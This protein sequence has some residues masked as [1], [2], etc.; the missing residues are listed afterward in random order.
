MA[1]NGK[2]TKIIRNGTGYE[3]KPE[4]NMPSD[5]FT[6]VFG[7][8]PIDLA[9]RGLKHIAGKNK[10]YKPHKDNAN[11]SVD[12]QYINK[13]LIKVL[14]SSNFYGLNPN[15][16][17]SHTAIHGFTFNHQ[18]QK[19]RRST[20]LNST[21]KAWT[22]LNQLQSNQTGTLYAFDLETFGG[23]SQ[24]KRWNPAGIT[25]FAMRQ[26]D[27]AT[28]KSK[29]TNI[30]FTNKATLDAIEE[31]LNVYK[32]LMRDGIS[33]KEMKEK[34]NDVYVTA[35]RMSLYDPARGAAFE[36]VNGV[37]QA[38]AL[39]DTKEAEAGNVASVMNA[40][41]N[42]RKMQ[43]DVNEHTGLTADVEALIR[44]TNQMN[45]GMQT[46]EAVVM[47]HNIVNF[48]RPILSKAINDIY[49]QQVDIYRDK[50]LSDERRQQ[51]FNALQ[52]FHIDPNGHVGFNFDNMPVL[53]T[54]GGYRAVRDELGM[55][56]PSLQ[57]EY[58][59]ERYMPHLLNQGVSHLGINDVRNNISIVLDK[60][61]EL[62]GQSPFEYIMNEA[63]NG[64]LSKL[65]SNRPTV[66]L[67]NKQLFKATGNML[68]P[69]F[70]GK[71]FLNYI[72][73]N[74]GEIYTAGGYHIKDGNIT[75]TDYA[76]NTGF[77]K[78]GFYKV[79][80]QERI[81]VRNLPKEMQEHLLSNYP[82]YNSKYIYHASF[83]NETGVGSVQGHTVNVFATSQEE[84]E[85]I[86][87]S[88]LAHVANATDDGGW[89]IVQG[90]KDELVTAA[91]RFKNNRVYARKEKGSDTNIVKK[92]IRLSDQRS[93]NDAV[94]RAVYNHEKS[95]LRIQGMLNFDEEIRK[96][97]LG[98]KF[99]K[100]L[101]DN[102][103]LS[104]VLVNDGTVNGTQYFSKR[105]M[106]KINATL[107]KHIGYES[108]GQ[109]F[110]DERTKIN[111]AEEYGNIVGR[112]QYYTNLLETTKEAM[113]IKEIDSKNAT[114]ATKFFK[115]LDKKAKTK[116]I[117]D[118][119]N[120]NPTGDVI[121]KAKEAKNVY[122]NTKAYFKS[123]YDFKLGDRFDFVGEKA[124]LIQ[125]VWSGER[126]DDIVS[127]N[128][129]E[130][131]AGSKFLN[132]LYKAR[133][134]HKANQKNISQKE[135]DANTQQAFYSFLMDLNENR[136]ANKLLFKDKEFNSYMGKILDAKLISNSAPEGFDANEGVMYLLNAVNKAKKK[137]MGAGII[138]TFGD[139]NIFNMNPQMTK[140]LNNL[141]A[142]VIK[143][144]GK[145]IGKIEYYDDKSKQRYVKELVNIFGINQDLFDER[146]AGLNKYEK[147]RARII[148]DDIH[149]KLSVYFDDLL[150]ATGQHGVGLTIDESNQR[151]V[152][153][154][155]NRAQELYAMPKFQIDEHG[156]IHV[157]SGGTDVG[158]SLRLAVKNGK[159]YL[160]TN[161]D[162]SF[163][164][165]D[166]FQKIL[167]SRKNETGSIDLTDLNRVLKLH[168]QK[169]KEFTGYTG[170]KN[171]LSTLNS[172][173][174]LSA[175]SELYYEMFRKNG[176]LNHLVDKI[177]FNNKDLAAL[178]RKNAEKFKD[179]NIPPDLFMAGINDFVNIMKVTLD[180]EDDT[181]KDT[182]AMLEQVGMS[183]KETKLVNGLVQLGGRVVGNYSNYFDNVGRPPMTGAG[184]VKQIRIEDIKKLAKHGVIAGSIF[185]SEETLRGIYR[186]SAGIEMV[187]DFRARQAYMSAPII[188]TVLEKNRS[189]VLSANINNAT[190]EQMTEKQKQVVYDK[191]IENMA[192]GT[193]EQARV[194][195]GR[196]LN[197]IID[198]PI[199]TSYLSVNK[200]I[201]GA[202]G[203]GT[204]QDKFARLVDLAGDITYDENTKE[205]VYKRR[206]GSIV[207]KGESIANYVG[208]G[209][210]QN[211]YGSKYDLGLLSYSIRNKEN[212]ELSDEEVSKIINLYRER[213]DAVDSKED[214]LH[215]LT[216]VMGAYG[217]KTSYKIENINQASIYKV[218]DQGSEK[219]MSLAMNA[220]LGEYNKE[221]SEYFKMFGQMAEEFGLDKDKYNLRGKVVGREKAILAM[222][223]D[224]MSAVNASGKFKNAKNMNDIVQMIYGR[225][226]HKKTNQTIG[227]ILD[228]I[229]D[230]RDV[231][232]EMAFGE[233][234]AFKNLF[235]IVNDAIPKHE[236]LGLN[237]FANFNEA[238]YKYEIAKYGSHSEENYNKA[239]TF[240][241]EQ[242]NTNN[243]INFLRQ[244]SKGSTLNSVG[245]TFS[246][247][248]SSTAIVNR[249]EGEFD[250][251][252]DG[253][254]TN[255]MKF[256]N[257]LIIK[258]DANTPEE[259]KLVHE[260]VY[261]YK[262]DKTTGKPKLEKQETLVGSFKFI[263]EDGKKIAISATNFG[264]HSIVN[265]GETISGVTQEYINAKMALNE[266]RLKENLT[267]ED[268]ARIKELSEFVGSQK[269]SVKFM[270]IDDQGMT[271]MRRN[272]FNDALAE[273]LGASLR[274]TDGREAHFN[275]EKAKMLSAKTGDFIRYDN[276]KKSFALD[277]EI[278]NRGENQVWIE[279][280]M[281]KQF[282]NDYYGEEL[283]EEML[284][285]P[286]Y[287]HL[288]EVREYLTGTLKADKVGVY[289]AENYYNADG[290]ITAHRFNR[291]RMTESDRNALI[292]KSNF[293]LM[294]I[295]DYVSAEGSSNSEVIG[296]IANK[297]ILLDLGD[298]FD[299][300]K[301]YIAIPEGGMAVGDEEALAKWQ[302]KINHLKKLQNKLDALEGAGKLKDNAFYK[303]LS[304]EDKKAYIETLGDVPQN[305]VDE[306]NMILDQMVEARQGIIDTINEGPR[307]DSV[308]SKISKLEIT[309]SQERLKILS[310][311]STSANNEALRA[312][313]IKQEIDLASESF[314]KTAKIMQNDGTGISLHELQEKGVHYDVER[315]G[316]DYFERA[317]Y[318]D[319]EMLDKM[320]FTTEEEMEQYLKE[321]GTMRN[322][323]RYPEILDTSKF[324]TRIFYDESMNG[325]NGISVMAHSMLKYNGDSD[326]DSESGFNVTID[327]V[328]FAIF[329]RQKQIATEQLKAEGNTDTG[330]MFQKTLME[331]V[332]KNGVVTEDA[333][334]GFRDM[335]LMQDVMAHTE[336]VAWAEKA[337]GDI[338]DD[339]TKNVKVGTIGGLNYQIKD[340]VSDT[341]KNARFESMHLELKS[342]ELKENISG[343]KDAIS[344]VLQQSPD[345]FKD[346]TLEIAQ[347]IAGGESTISDVR[348]ANK[349]RILDHAMA[350][351]EQSHKNGIITDDQFE[352]MQSDL[353]KRVRT[354]Q[355]F[356]EQAS[357]S[358]KSAIGSINNALN[359]L[360]T[361]TNIM[362]RDEGSEFYDLNAANI[363]QELTYQLEQQVISGKKVAFELGD[364]RLLEV[365]DILK[366]A[367]LGKGAEAKEDLANWMDTYFDKGTTERIWSRM[368]PT[369]RE[370]LIKNKTLENA[371]AE[372]MKNNTDLTE[373][374][375]RIKAMNQYLANIMLDASTVIANSE[376][377]KNTVHHMGSINKKTSTFDNMDN[378]TGAGI[379]GSMVNNAVN[380]L[381]RKSVDEI[382][383]MA[384]NKGVELDPI[385]Q[386]SVKQT[387]KAITEAMADTLL[388]DAKL[389]FS[390]GAVLGMAAIGVGAGLMIAGYAGGGHSRPTPP[391]D[392]TQ[393]A[394]LPPD[395]DEGGEPGMQQ[396]GYVI[397]I[398]ADT[399]KGERHLKKTLKQLKSVSN[400]GNVNINMNYKRTNG[401]G[402][403]NK[404]IENI[405][406]NFI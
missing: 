325:K 227:G 285:D 258:L 191:L 228:L 207:K 236:N 388:K 383:K 187:S 27:F 188:Q 365:E 200:D 307:K 226:G 189:N 355:M 316:R 384:H 175:V 184:N 314:M 40:F 309:E 157:Q 81:E 206:A 7:N 149:D 298:E 171:D 37:W 125:D 39:V 217:L 129:N 110:L 89:Q 118:A 181:Y 82:E 393:P 34:H 121:S 274:L 376:G 205:Y 29:D 47:G 235:G 371:A 113:G 185:E 25:E 127:I 100:M 405:I 287:A 91:Y 63:K 156:V 348:G 247:G 55:E 212:K 172:V 242:M 241:T 377:G 267:K 36:Q 360:K 346:G 271:I 215:T 238:V 197:E 404:D 288:K 389:G 374:Q 223:E 144:L 225:N 263:E 249:E 44:A 69:E 198:M 239:L 108:K 289:E 136:K 204:N 295:K 173:F 67:N 6:A 41:K 220:T 24:D 146:T 366:K 104:E 234:G 150:S 351:I 385:S 336:N 335:S 302:G 210:V 380:F 396:H 359:A 281:K 260:D 78:G 266:L 103:S 284:K 291:G 331:R 31:Q 328:N 22:K 166:T 153:T 109:M 344:F 324:N 209:G 208:Y 243:D 343:V 96:G 392:D 294:S 26:H 58:L 364:T 219:G 117:M 297:R 13:D 221:V 178:Y 76:G 114:G 95:A 280:M 168:N 2:N 119:A 313:G 406:N 97:K 177:D 70:G 141:D 293:E 17:L 107:K 395:F 203:R 326:G 246:M 85:A 183:L 176:S 48:D 322:V 401:G 353:I 161:F 379:G 304:E 53:D 334:I 56:L 60:L 179:G 339:I 120:G 300:S 399:N 311:T 88:N 264:S 134:G 12:G 381:N 303:S 262:I 38:T 306:R 123:T 160:T 370:E 255:F 301:R 403:S 90:Q 248:Q 268:K 233:H 147:E 74:T 382:E 273:D 315:V 126:D 199:D 261:V 216:E 145:D 124:Q 105:D 283:T 400:G 270:K 86:L 152:A 368:R 333:Y 92:A 164:S 73:Y 327:G 195:D 363:T 98:T 292:Q 133:M 375:A 317:G 391:K 256:T 131:N 80:V 224:L 3:L 201:I 259:D 16:P 99:D 320:G 340:S 373:D 68:T 278:R 180:E 140:N 64:G 174:D 276:N 182:V 202:I 42:F 138:R 28:G 54:L 130:P 286:K 162:E 159:T 296:S 251:I 272:R 128:L 5:K 213:F 357:K 275:E 79:G 362:M 23:T 397:N 163:G 190:I 218:L 45:I 330:A 350:A 32:Q 245:K 135:I 93:R 345:A 269:D 46:G 137:D 19:G 43:L 101:A 318:F 312:L 240:L 356:E 111:V 231:L 194:V 354:Q 21:V 237:T 386:E 358:T 112:K 390:G 155:G 35:M 51:A 305:L 244:T 319:K 65:N 337:R 143:S 33:M 50:S 214:M 30:L 115:E 230:E 57:L 59:T 257:D 1:Y 15:T 8:K 321:Y 49:R 148:R 323:T 87:G 372:L 341:F 387:Q 329:E 308:V 167:T 222:H 169:T 193:Y 62:N 254:F 299:E 394:Q 151:L 338:V 75:H 83:I 170:S 352:S 332:I 402:Y 102:V 186:E 253:K 290:L 9:Q 72:Q 361:T 349:Y 94:Q 277:D 398:K 139:T 61:P 66:A 4:V 106:Q 279:K 265:D 20:T 229:K 232:S 10:A 158:V 250:F 347:S 211:S 77:R 310:I 14:N 116:V 154:L 252:D 192:S 367:K 71:G 122:T 282:Y 11:T 378:N 18:E 84:M 342:K 369:H 142:D 132:K 196:I 52:L 165:K